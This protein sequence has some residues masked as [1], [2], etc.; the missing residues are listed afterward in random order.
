MVNI[1]N[2]RL[3]L[4][5]LLAL[6]L[7]SFS[8][9]CIGNSNEVATAKPKV[10]TISTTTSLYDTGILENV[11]APIFKEKYNIELRFI[12][13]GTGGAIL[14]AKSGAS[15]AIL[16][17][18]LPKEQAFMEEG[19]GVNRKVFAY[20][21]FVIVG[22]KDDPAGIRGL[23]VSEALKKIVEYG[24]AHPDKI[25]WVSRDDGSGTNTKEI[26]LW[27]NAGFDFNELKNES[28]F[29]TTGAGMG[30]TLLYTSERKAYTISDIGTYLKYQKEGKINLDV[31][32]DKGEELIN[33]YAIIIINPK[34]IPGKDFKDAMLLAEWLT[35]DEGQK[36]IAEY[37]KDEFGRPLFYPAVPV[38]KGEQGD[39]FR[40]I[41]KYGFMK[42]GDKYTECPEKFRYNA[43][44]DFFEFPAS[45]VGG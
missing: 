17:H 5:F 40:W 24:R 38:L 6:I 13:K 14:D 12:P 4:G 9:G 15:D 39:V 44:Y 42:D 23:S 45:V 2:K 41:L 30:N 35:S 3:K 10:L 22:P 28:W 34:K 18:A 1:M 33:V 25:V 11:V 20:N 21:F 43:T 29:G 19:Y 26:A 27:K 37:G 16:V 8:Y 36:A 32:V 7:V 31:L